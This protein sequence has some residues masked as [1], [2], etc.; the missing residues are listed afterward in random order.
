MLAES[1]SP[2][3]PPMTDDALYEQLNA[4]L[5]FITAEIAGLRV[6]QYIFW[7]VQEIIR[8]NQLIN[9]PNEFYT[10]MSDAYAA[11]MSAAIRRQV[12]QRRDTISFL[13]F[14][15]RLKAQPTV[16]TRSRYKTFSK[17]APEDFMNE[18]FAALVG[19]GMVAMKAAD[20]EN[21]IQALGRKVEALKKY[22]DLVVAHHGKSVPTTIPKFKDLDE[23][24]E[25]LDSL[26][27]KY[28]HLFRSVK[29]ASALPTFIDDWKAIFRVPWISS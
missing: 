6:S 8:A 4:E 1:H 16:V 27:T 23:A 18:D 3:G 25:L 5:D 7:E 10:W 22:A 29:Q 12:D 11:S 15:Q 28:L 17:T 21:D 26:L 20:V 9:K 14:L 2:F 19:S 24:I 13:R